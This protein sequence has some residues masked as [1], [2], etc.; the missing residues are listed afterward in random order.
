MSGYAMDVLTIKRTINFKLINMKKTLLLMSAAALTMGMAQAAPQTTVTFSA[1]PLTPPATASTQD[2]RANADAE[3]NFLVYTKAGEPGG[4]YTL[5]NMPS[6]CT[7]YLATEMTVADQQPFIGCTIT[8]VNVMA[9]SSQNNGN[10]PVTKVNAF[11]TD[12]PDAVPENRTT[13]EINT[14]PYSVTSIK[15]D[16]PV[17]ITGEKPLYFGY[18]F[19][20]TSARPCYF[21]PSDL[22]PTKSSTNNTLVAVVEKLTDAPK[23]TNYSHQE[24]GSLCISVNI[25]GDNLPKDL[26]IITGLEVPSFVNG[27][28]DLAYSINIK[29]NGSNAL[30]SA[31]VKTEFSHGGV[32]ESE[33]SFDTPIE[34]GKTGAV[35]V[36]D[37]PNEK[38]GIFYLTSTLEKV[39]GVAVADPTSMTASFGTYSNGYKR[40]PVMEEATGAWCQWCPAGIVMMETLAKEYPDWIRIAVHSGDRMQAGTYAQFLNDYVPGFPYAVANR[41]YGLYPTAVNA[42][43]YEEMNSMFSDPAYASV[44]LDAKCTEDQKKVSISSTVTACCD[45]DVA[46]MLSF[47]IV[48]DEVGPYAQANRYAGGGEG[49]MGGWEDKDSS[50]S[51]LFDDVARS[52]NT[53][54]GIANSLPAKLEGGKSY[55]YDLTMPVTNVIN[56]WFRVIAL[57]TNAE[58]GEIVNA[59]EITAYKDNGAGVDGV[60]SDNAG[61]E[62][63]GGVGEIIVTG[64][65]N[66]AVYTLD[67]RQVG[68]T[69]L[70][71]GVYIVNADGMSCKVL[72]K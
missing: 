6:R 24:P 42:S 59:Q 48:E 70:A 5:N 60:A 53:Y 61:I 19:G 34:P 23:F 44:S 72:V 64:T 7:V 63:N 65:A 55:N 10:F 29:N 13:S 54:P 22:K 37:V 49:P 26:G 3:D 1:S 20:Y 33:I 12:T 69:G 28:S 38:E 32:Y 57:I 16:K 58:T 15:L 51:T 39:N 27:G 25:T 35:A 18:F 46:H 11:V 40:R 43:T 14:T 41:V 2:V 17:V 67:G 36:K 50:V 56:S 4:I 62:I 68:T 21:M 30:T 71:G 31:V 45:V 9:G 8:S 47:V 52:I 66:V